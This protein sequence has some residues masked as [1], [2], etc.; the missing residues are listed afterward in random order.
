MPTLKPK[1]T[2]VFSSADSQRALEAALSDRCELNRTSMSLE[3]ER[4]LIEALIPRDGGFAERPVMRIYYGMGTVQSELA[5]I[6]ESN[7]AG[8]DWKARHDDERPLVELASQQ[9]IGLTLDLSK[10]YGGGM[11]PVYHARSCWESVCERLERDV[12]ELDGDAARAARVD[13]EVARRLLSQLN[14]AAA[15]P[16]AKAFFDLVLRNWWSLGNYTYTFRALMDV[17]DMTAGWPE[18]AESRED[19]KAAVTAISDGRGGAN[20]Q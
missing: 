18:T 2:L 9:S 15:H 5:G 14:D 10:E 11:M 16:E 20:A 17:V 3:I 6:F 7:A 19:F 13:V 4:I 12:E 1:R 8:I